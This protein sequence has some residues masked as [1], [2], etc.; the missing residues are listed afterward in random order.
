MF[1]GV[2]V[3]DSGDYADPRLL[4]DMARDAE[5][6]GWDGFFMWDHIAHPPGNP[7]PVTDP[8]VAL[9]AIASGTT[10]IRFGALVT[11]LARRRPW[12]LARELVALDALG[13][14]RLVLG[15]GLGEPAETEF[16]AFGEDS[17]AKTRAGR[18]DESLEILAG[19]WTGQPF[20]YAGT[21]YQLDDVTFLPTPV[22]S[23]RIPIW[24]AGEW[25]NK[26]P[27]RR[28]ARWDGIF[29]SKRGVAVDEMMSPRDLREIVTFIMDERAT[30][31][32]FTVALGGYTPASDR[33][34]AAHIVGQYIDAGLTYWL[35]GLNALRLT[36]PEAR[37]RI[38][39]GPPKP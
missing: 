14:G 39:Q 16:A 1:Y 10:R 23:P 7:L 8:T 25:P 4:A 24:V 27:F 22:Q 19:L 31:A 2:H 18:L 28:A 12:K 11:P 15:V 35:E 29:P 3:Q 5:E 20:S 33:E 30:D 38:W 17:D 36:L 32:P 37:E 6:A 9:A 34:R 21:H 13:N 26:P